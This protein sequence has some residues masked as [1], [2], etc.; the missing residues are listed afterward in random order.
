M[1]RSTISRSNAFEPLSRRF[2][3]PRPLLLTARTE[4]FLY[5]IQD[6]DETIRRL[7]AFESAGRTSSMPPGY[8]TSM[9]CEP[10]S[11]LLGDPSTSSWDL[12][13]PRS[14]PRI[15]P[16]S[17][18]GA[19]VSGASCAARSA[20]L[21]GRRGI[22]AERIFRI[23]TPTR[24]DRD[25]AGSPPHSRRPHPLSSIDNGLGEF[26]VCPRRP[27]EEVEES[28]GGLRLAGR[29][30][31]LRASVIRWCQPLR[32]GSSDAIPGLRQYGPQGL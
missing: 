31:H 28:D 30:E 19:R 24:S 10:M 21:P 22:H 13:I 4:N 11:P 17:A 5:G 8:E 7:Q 14:G 29:S 23:P 1:R 16:R 32:G 27:G 6:L 26:E 25:S 9:K 12:P 15:S 18:F 2:G 3:L 20:L